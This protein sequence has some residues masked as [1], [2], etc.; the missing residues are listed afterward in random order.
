M[1]GAA[2]SSAGEGE[3]QLASAVLRGAA[4]KDRA[5]TCAGAELF[6]NG[7][8]WGLPYADAVASLKAVSEI[9]CVL[10]DPRRTV[11]HRRPP[12]QLARL[13]GEVPA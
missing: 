10:S 9:L 6:E 11:R 7:P 3:V 1:S 8:R 2:P 12:P 5:T 13:R 4:T